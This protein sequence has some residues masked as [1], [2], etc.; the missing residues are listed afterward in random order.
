LE[1]RQHQFLSCL[2]VLNLGYAFTETGVPL[3]DFR[4]HSM[5]LSGRPDW[6]AA[7]TTGGN[8]FRGTVW[9][10][11][12]VPLPAAFVRGLDKQ[13]SDFEGKE[14]S[15]LAGKW[16]LGGWWYYYLV[17]LQYKLPIGTLLLF[18]T[19]CV[20][21]IT[22]QSLR[23]ATRDELLVLASMVAIVAFVSA[24]TGF[25]H[26]V[27]YVVPALGFIYVW[28]G[29]AGSLLT[30]GWL[31]TIAVCGCAIGA[32]CSSLAV[33]PISFSY[34]NELIGGPERAGE[35]FSESNVAWGQDLFRLKQWL[36]EHP[37]A[38]KIFLKDFEYVDLGIL[39]ISRRE[40]S[41]IAPSRHENGVST[42][43]FVLVQGWYVINVC[44]LHRDG[45]EC[46]WFRELTPTAKIGYSYRVY[47]VVIERSSRRSLAQDTRDFR[48]GAEGTFTLLQ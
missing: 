36:D 18:F 35:Y 24:Q 27:R 37:E 40:L 5:A 7:R 23:R 30:K 2:A 47:Q 3:K 4:F 46:K 44:F 43:R 45:P 25:N 11:F 22:P 17:G 21:T 29:K 1:R 28:I 6:Q 19:A 10:K 48:A 8:R 31:G 34:A 32:V 13:K 14:Y 39:G 42:G 33:F 38:G 12:R 26:H 16:K 9:G 41:A 20:L 15:F